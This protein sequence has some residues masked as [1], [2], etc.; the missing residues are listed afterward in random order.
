[1]TLREALK[2]FRSGSPAYLVLDQNGKLEGYCGRSELFTALR[3]GR[4]LDTHMRDFMRRDTPVVL[5]NQTVLDASV[6]MLR[7]DVE[8]LPVATADGSGKIVGI[9]SPFDVILKAIEPLSAI[10]D[11]RETPGDRKL[12]S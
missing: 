6:V 2:R 8:L 4:S 5:E 7:E 1:M 11:F 12:A 9:M 3:S 10:S